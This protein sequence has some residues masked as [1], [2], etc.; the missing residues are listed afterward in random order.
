YAPP[1]FAFFA[2]DA[3][4]WRYEVSFEMV[5]SEK[6]GPSG[7]ERPRT[8][9]LKADGAGGGARAALGAPERDGGG[10]DPSRVRCEEAADASAEDTGAPAGEAWQ[11]ATSER[12][13]ERAR[14]V[15]FLMVTTRGKRRSARAAFLFDLEACSGPGLGE[16]SLLAAAR[17]GG[18]RGRQRPLV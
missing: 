13:S 14:R 7:S 12:T 2:S 6:N 1:G 15:R 11:Q 5:L 18:R 3:A 16:P 8:A 4:T 10:T 9:A 17:A